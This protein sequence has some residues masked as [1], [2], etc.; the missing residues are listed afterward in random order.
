MSGGDIAGRRAMHWVAVGGVAILAQF[1]LR[2][3]ADRVGDQ[4]PALRSFVN[5][6]NHSE[7]S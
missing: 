5:Y 6:V 3:L 2:V 4:A 7:G 1:A